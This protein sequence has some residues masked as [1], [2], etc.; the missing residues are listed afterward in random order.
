VRTVTV[1]AEYWAFSPSTITAKRGERVEIQLVGIE[2]TH[3]FSVPELGINVTISAGETKSF[4]LPT[5]QA[6]TFHLLCS[7]QCG[8]GH[9]GMTGQ[10]VI[11]P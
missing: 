7:I 11:E 4:T 9:S 2:G 1:T 10:I 6:G 5:D 3:G 8:A